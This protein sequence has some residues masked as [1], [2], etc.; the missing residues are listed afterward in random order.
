MKK[1]QHNL[2]FKSKICLHSRTNSGKLDLVLSKLLSF[3]L[4]RCKGFHSSHLP[5]L[6]ISQELDDAITVHVWSYEE[7]WHIEFSKKS[8]PLSQ[9]ILKFKNSQ[10]KAEC[11]DL[12]VE[13]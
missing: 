13:S 10:K 4:S 1:S 3:K 5:V 11:P 8:L 9:V 12:L 2:Q 7:L 6:G